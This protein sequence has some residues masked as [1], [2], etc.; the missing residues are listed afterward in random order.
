MLISTVVTQPATNFGL[1]TLEDA[2]LALDIPAGDT[3][4]DAALTHQIE[5][6][7][8]FIAS[9][10]NRV[11]AKEGVIETY[12]KCAA[13]E[14]FLNRWPVKPADVVEITDNGSPVSYAGDYPDDPSAYQLDSN[15]GMIFRVD[16]WTGPTVATYAGGYTLP[17]ESP[18]ALQQAMGLLLRQWYILWVGRGLQMRA[19]MHKSSRV[20]YYDPNAAANRGGANAATMNA[21][22][23][24]LMHFT[25][26]WC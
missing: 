3:S 20:M 26:L 14:I 13:Q 9:M 25:R 7:S 2:K 11:F 23:K 15:S 18:L 17:T 24:L 19:V 6:Q 4:A 12:R 8:G 10:C 1:M 22:D 16:G 5:V 21:L